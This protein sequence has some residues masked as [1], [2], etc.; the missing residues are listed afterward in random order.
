MSN[1]LTIARRELSSLFFSPIAYVVLGLFALG[2]SWIFVM[3]F[4]PGEPATLRSTFGAIVWLMIFLVPAIS[5]RLVSDELRSGTL[6]LLMT[7]PLS[8]VQVILGKWL[9]AMGFYVVLLSPLMVHALVIEAFAEPDLGPVLTGF[10]G[11]MLV[12]GLYL[13]IGTF[14]STLA[15]NQIIAFLVTIFLICILTFVTF[16]VP[17]ADNVWQWLKDSMLYL[18]INSQYEDF[19][20]GLI[21]SSSV[22]YFLVGIALFLYF[23]VISL[24]SRRWR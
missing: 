18:N 24:E 19:T 9:G 10:L 22:A 6:E 11:L 21:D 15:Q 7:S 16:F 14:A 8:D 4:G 12:G 2:A 23:A 5:M 17:R 13:A 20:K 3:S 1:I